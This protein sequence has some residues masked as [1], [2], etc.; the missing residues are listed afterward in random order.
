MSRKKPVGDRNGIQK[1]EGV[2]DYGVRFVTLILTQSDKEAIKQWTYSPE[3]ISLELERQID[4]GY[5]IS[6]S[7]DAHNCCYLVSLT[8]GKLC[9]TK[10]NVGACLVSRGGSLQQAFCAMLYKLENYCPEGVSPTMHEPV[11]GEIS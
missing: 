5:K 2:N 7:Y 8:G 4:N 3:E 6:F 11:P 10:E 1:S 9:L